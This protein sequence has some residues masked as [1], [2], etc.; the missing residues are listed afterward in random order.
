MRVS[1]S[2]LLA[3]SDSHDAAVIGS[4]SCAQIHTLPGRLPAATTLPASPSTRSFRVFLLHTIALQ[5]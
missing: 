1:F 4:R 3:A 5:A 2:S